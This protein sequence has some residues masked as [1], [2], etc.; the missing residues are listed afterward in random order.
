MEKYPHY[1]S[2]LIWTACYLFCAVFWAATF[3]VMGVI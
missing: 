1:T 3:K 2:V